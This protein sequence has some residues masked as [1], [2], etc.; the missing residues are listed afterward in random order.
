MSINLLDDYLLYKI[1]D[2]ILDNKTSI[3][4]II[5]CKYFK[6]IFYKYGYIKH[7]KTGNLTDINIYDFFSI[8]VEHENTLDLIEITNTFNPI[9]W[10]TVWPRVVFFNYCN[11]TVEINPFKPVKTKRLYLLNNRNN[12]KIKIHWDMFPDLEYLETDNFNFN[13]E[14]IKK[15]LNIRI[16]K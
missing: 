10:I 3:N 1:M 8:C 9:N 7:I 16:K 11:I 14:D 15:L 5:S 13:F 12:K 6:D 4:F 2:Y